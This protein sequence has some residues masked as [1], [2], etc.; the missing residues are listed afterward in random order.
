LSSRRQGI[1]RSGLIVAGVLVAAGKDIPGAL[2][3]NKESQG[4]DVPE[5]KEQRYWLWE[6][7]S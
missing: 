7:S 1:G 6:F 3:T 4:L 2:R 5:T